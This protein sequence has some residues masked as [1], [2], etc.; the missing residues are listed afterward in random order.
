MSH[1]TQ[2]AAWVASS[3]R[4]L[5][6]LAVNALGAGAQDGARGIT[7]D[8]ADR[9]QKHHL[10]VHEKNHLLVVVYAPNVFTVHR[11][12]VKGADSQ[13]G[14]CDLFPFIHFYLIIL[15]N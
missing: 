5:H 15:L 7:Q 14:V 2:A 8:E 9:V 11:P 3:P 1:S 6:Q 10:E 12:S 13:A 4:S